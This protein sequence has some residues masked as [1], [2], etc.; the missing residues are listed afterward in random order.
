MMSARHD[1]TLPNGPADGSHGTD[2]PGGH[3][4]EYSPPGPNLH[5]GPIRLFLYA[6]ILDTSRSCGRP[7]WVAYAVFYRP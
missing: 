4:E 2:G 3:T 7:M 6:F 1:S 5:T